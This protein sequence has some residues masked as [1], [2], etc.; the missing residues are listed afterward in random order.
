MNLIL[1]FLIFFS[2]IGNKCDLHEFHISKC[3]VEYKAE[4][5]EIQVSVNIF[6]DDLEVALKEMGI[7]G[8]AIGTEKESYHADEYIN[9]YLERTFWLGINTKKKVS[10]N[11]IG[12]ETSEDL[13]S[14]WCYLQIDAT[15][16]IE[17]LYI[18]NSILL[19]IYEDQKNITSIIGPNSKKTSFM[20]SVGDDHKTI[21]Y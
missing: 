2:P 8:M 18:K 20:S 4:K 1:T 10:W 12:K 9:K 6:I 19:E 14:I 17:Q 13:S 3:L 5:K 15:E 11:F 21:S 16:D 7:E